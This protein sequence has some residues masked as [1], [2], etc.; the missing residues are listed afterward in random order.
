MDGVCSFSV[1]VTSGVPQG[2]VLGP[3]MF[4]LFVNN[5]QDDLECSLRLF[6][7]DAPLYHTI[8]QD[9]DTLTLQRDLGNWG[10]G[11]K[12]GR[13]CLIHLNATKCLST[14]LN[15]PFI[16]TTLCTTKA[17]KQYNSILT[18]GCCHMT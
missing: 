16:E 15:P 14:E 13:W 18:W 7:D 17:S 9:S 10:Y 2:T 1:A 3:L 4:L 8:S 12:N 11:P 5:M 6:A